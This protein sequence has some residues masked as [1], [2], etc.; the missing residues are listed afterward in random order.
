MDHP[1]A[2]KR[3][4]RAALKWIGLA[5]SGLVT[6][7]GGYLIYVSWSG[8]PKYEVHLPQFKAEMTPASV[9]RGKKLAKLMCAGCHENPTTHRFTGHEMTDFPSAF[10]KVFSA[11]ITRDPKRG[12]GSW[13]DAELAYLLRTGIRRDGQYLPPW[14]IKVPHLSD[15]DLSAL[16]AYLRSDDPAVAPAE[17]PPAGQ[18][19][20]SLLSKVLTH[21]VMKPLPYPSQPIVAPARTDRVAYGRYLTVG[22]DCFGCH[23]GDFKKVDPMQPERSA[24]YM[25]GGTILIGVD[26]RE[27][28]S[29]NITPDESAG[30]GLWREEDFVRA[31]RQGV[32]P[33]GRAL[34]YPMLPKPE[35]TEDE[36]A[37]IYAYLRTIPKIKKR[38]QSH[39]EQTSSA[40]DPGER[41]YSQYGCNGCHG[42][43]GEGTTGVPDLNHVNDHY[44][45]DSHLRAWIESPQTTK[46]ETK[47]PTWKGIIKDEDYQPL[48]RYLR[49][50]GAAPGKVAL[51]Q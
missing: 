48:I 32:R 15:A 10:G 6:L 14:M 26:G 33:D 19:R 16:I 47:M 8:I 24:G 4:V 34:R 49:S 38:V 42:D 18:T 40:S 25:G 31:L 13:S 12:I 1:N 2:N 44:P 39:V 46:P 7:I 51:T 22:L 27:I 36:V 3:P 45:D 29:A 23:S 17:V 41:L 28:P 20:P 35:L 21:T 37:A 9:E 5:L 43:K 50:L 11:N 30:I